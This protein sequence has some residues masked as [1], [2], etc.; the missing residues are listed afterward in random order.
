VYASIAPNN[1]ASKLLMI[2]PLNS[3][4]LHPFIFYRDNSEIKVINYPLTL[5]LRS[6]AFSRNGWRRKG[7]NEKNGR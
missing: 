6:A 1:T 3:P 2:S 5:A 4:T 7:R